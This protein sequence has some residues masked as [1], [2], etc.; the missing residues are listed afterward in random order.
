MRK[1]LPKIEK[2][3]ELVAYYK[4]VS[5]WCKTNKELIYGNN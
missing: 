1:A 5:D 2:T 3:P 4:K